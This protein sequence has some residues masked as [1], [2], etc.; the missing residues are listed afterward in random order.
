MG[1]V[2]GE[3]AL[4]LEGVLDPGQHRVEGAGQPPQLVVRQVEVEAGVQVPAADPGRQSRDRGDRRQRPAGQEVAAAG[5]GDERER[6]GQGEDRRAARPAPRRSRRGRDP[7]WR[8]PTDASPGA[9]RQ[10]DD[11]SEMM[12]RRVLGD[13]SA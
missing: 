11:P 7:T 9:H 4:P 12:V 1:G 2:A 6:D 8:T 5:G 10:R 3:A 13:P